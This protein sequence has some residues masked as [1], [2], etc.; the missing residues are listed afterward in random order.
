MGGLLDK[1]NAAK[2]T[3]DTEEPA[4]VKAAAE[5]PNAAEGSQAHKTTQVGN[6]SSNIFSG[7]SKVG[8]GL[9]GF[10]FV[11]M[12]FL[13]SYLLEDLTG[14]VPF[15]LVVLG[16]FG[17]SFYMVW[18]SIEREKTVVLAVIYI[19]LAAVPYGAGLLGGGFVGITDIAYSEEGDELTF[20]IRGGFNSVD[21]FIKADGETVWSG[22]EDLSND[23]KNFR[24][25]IVDF[26]AG[27]GE[28]HDGKADVD[29]T[30]YAE[31]SDGLTG[32]VGIPSKLVTRQA[33]DAGVRINALQGFESNNEYLGITVNILVGLINPDYQNSNGG[34]FQA[35]GLRPMNGDYTIDVTVTGGDEWSESTMTVDEDVATWASQSPGVGSAFT[36]GWMELTGTAEESATG[37]LY[38]AKEDFY[39]DPGCYSFTVDIVNIVSP[40]EVFS[41][42]WSWEI[43]LESGD[44][45]N[46]IDRGEGIGSTC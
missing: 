5:V 9:G 43:D 18:D 46:G 10:A 22:S 25:P 3:E 39:D 1:A 12:W 30:I 32:E 45:E 16:I 28:F 4:P 21:V 6:D 38:L 33:E 11:L 40:T 19:L 35:V 27:N 34:G 15:G 23:M 8:L 29:Y 20:K 17:A 2:E 36:D 42:T 7:A 44:D 24:V 14:P 31:S 26:F 37:T 41:T 13:G